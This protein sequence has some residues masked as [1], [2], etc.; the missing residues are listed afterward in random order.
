MRS[1]LERHARIVVIDQRTPVSF[2]PL[3]GYVGV[4]RICQRQSISD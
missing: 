1:R 4:R 2:V 3:C